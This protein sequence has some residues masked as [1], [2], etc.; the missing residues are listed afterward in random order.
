MDIPNVTRI[1]S[2]RKS[3]AYLT[4]LPTEILELIL[5]Y[6]LPNV[7]PQSK[8]CHHMDRGKELFRSYKLRIDCLIPGSEARAKHEYAIL[9]ANS[10]ISTAA[11]RLLYCQ[12]FQIE[13]KEKT[14]QYLNP[15]KRQVTL[16]D[17]QSLD[18]GTAWVEIYQDLTSAKL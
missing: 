4:N 1:A 11:R 14:F 5:Y 16:L 18:M 7:S 15:D 13:I 2:R 9:R 8:W 3:M 6:T 10:R 12:S 17:P